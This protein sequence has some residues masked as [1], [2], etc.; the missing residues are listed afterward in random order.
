[1]VPAIEDKQP[2]NNEK[3]IHYTCNDAIEY[4]KGLK[5][6]E[7]NQP[8]LIEGA[9]ISMFTLITQSENYA[10]YINEHDDETIE[11]VD[12]EKKKLVQTIKLKD[13]SSKDNE[14]FH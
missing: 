9:D 7:K 4:I 12:I 6:D 13:K 11:V 3:P 10:I 1:M 14:K 2:E 5:V 8:Q